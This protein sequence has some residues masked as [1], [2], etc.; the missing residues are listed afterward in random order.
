[1]KRR[2]HT[3]RALVLGAIAI[4]AAAI[5]PGC[6]HKEFWLPQQTSL[7][8]EYDWRDAPD[9]DPAG[10]CAIFYS[11]DNPS[12]TPR[13]FDFRGR[14]GGEI[15]LPEGTYRV[16]CFNNDTE[17]VAFRG[18]SAFDTH[19]AYT[20]EGSL[21]ESVTGPA[22]SSRRAY[23]DDE[24]VTLC[25][26]ELWG[27]NI[28][29]IDVTPQTR[30]ITLY[31]RDLLCH[32]SYEVRHVE[33]LERIAA[34]SAS[35]S[36]MSHAINLSTDAR[37]EEPVTIPFEA[38]VDPDSAKIKGEFLTFG[39]HPGRDDFRHQL[40]LYVWLR[41]AD[42]KRYVLGI[43]SDIHNVTLQVDTA[44]NYRRV[45]LVIDSL[46]IPDPGPGPDPGPDPDSPAYDASADDWGNI[47][48]DVPV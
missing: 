27:D 14:Q 42:R 38:R 18:S 46:R 22:A 32:Y 23:T 12:A 16:I 44:P 9:A 40:L 21:F 10:M 37:H 17:V 11:V 45:H 43:G 30:V 4:I 29:T 39:H 33:G 8:L 24:R 34:V 6:T 5:L 13:R 48:I 20:P 25:P 7:R 2:H 3:T 31:P 1:M 26:D 36:S 47:E 19:E 28:V 41:G 15:T 35:L